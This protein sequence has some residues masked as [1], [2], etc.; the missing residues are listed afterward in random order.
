MTDEFRNLS[1]FAPKFVDKKMQKEKPVKALAAKMVK[2]DI[3]EY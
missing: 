2:L 1:I 3:N